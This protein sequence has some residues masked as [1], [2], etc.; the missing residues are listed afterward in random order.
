MKRPP[1]VRQKLLGGI[2]MKFTC[3]QK[4]TVVRMVVEEYS[5]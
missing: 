3:E 1:K 2:F 4:L 5:G